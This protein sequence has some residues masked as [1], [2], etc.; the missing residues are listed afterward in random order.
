M[1]HLAGRH[2]SSAARPIHVLV[3]D[4]SEDDA[5]LITREIGRELGG[6]EYARV[7]TAEDMTRA[8]ASGHWDLVIADHR[9]PSFDSLG[10][11]AVLKKSGRDIPFVIYS[12]E[13]AHDTGVSAMQDGARDFVQKSTPSRLIA[14]IQREL[15]SARTRRDKEHAERSVVRLANY[16]QL[17]Q[18]PNRS[19]FLELMQL[20]AT[21]D[22]APGALLFVDLDRFMRINDSFGYATGDRLICQAAER[23]QSAIGERD[24]LA[25]LGQDEF[26]I[27]LDG[28][29]TPAG[30][31][32]AAA[33]LMQRFGGAF[34]H[35]GQ[36]FYLTCSIGVSLFPTDGTEPEVLVKNA[37]SAMFQAKKR[38]RNNVQLYRP[39][40]NRG[41]SRRVRLE[42]DLRHA[43][44]RNQLFL[45]FQPIVDL[46]SRQI[47]AAEALVRWRHA[48][49][50]IIAP[51]EFIGLA[52]ESGLIIGIGE[53]V[54]R[55]ACAQ[56]QRWRRTLDLDLVIAVNFSAAQFRQDNLTAE[57]ASV[58]AA[59]GLPP[60]ALE[61]EITE[62]VAMEDAKSTVRTLE[63]LHAMGV[64]VSI[65]DFGTGYSS[66]AYL[67][68]FPIDILKIDKSFVRDISIDPDDAAIVHTIT[69]LGQ[70]LKLLTLAEGVETEEQ[71]RYL[72]QQGCDRIQGYWIARPLPPEDFE[73]LMRHGAS[74]VAAAK[75]LVAANSAN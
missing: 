37:E 70:S 73:Q 31:C 62:T 59:T 68:R 40:L 64:R 65:D 22:A 36:D 24:L 74:N 60:R 67:K 4:D 21:T 7:D 71:A 18:L 26:V 28:V 52:D 12:G 46:R 45:L 30:A 38:G 48:E 34:G 29:D 55:A 50:G 54:L 75:S 3:V 49:L 47:V 42:N 35:A 41:S 63:A 39:E 6:V 13:V 25:R 57:I 17:T 15:E 61:I 2:A 43:V 16:D 8:L 5:F 23:L 72:A 66:L 1:P 33:R 11:L 19:M 20:H 14:V 32:A 10:A 53:W 51:D 9:M 27:F 69:A 44:E 58:L 56:M